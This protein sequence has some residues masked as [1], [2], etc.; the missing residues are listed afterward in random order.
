V[1]DVQ[2]PMVDERE[3]ERVP[4]GL[5]E[6]IDGHV[7]IFPDGLFAAVWRWFAE[8]GWPIRYQM[9]SSEVVGFL[10]SRGISHIVAFQYAHKPGIASEGGQACKISS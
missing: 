8:H 4:N 7:H 1:L 2:E 10:L 9:T 6:I 5:P 3:G